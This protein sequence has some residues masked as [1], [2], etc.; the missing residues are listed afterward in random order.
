[1]GDLSRAG[2]RQRFHEPE[3]P[4][5]SIERFA[6][7]DEEDE[8]PG[9][10]AEDEHI[11]DAEQPLQEEVNVPQGADIN[12]ATAA[13]V[14]VTT[15]VAQAA[16]A[17]KRGRGRPPK[18]KLTE[19][20]PKQPTPTVDAQT[21][22][23]QGELVAE[24]PKKT[25]VRSRKSMDAASTSSSA[26]RPSEE[27]SRTPSRTSPILP[28]T[29]LA[30]KKGAAT[31]SG[32]PTVDTL[33]GLS[34][35]KSSEMLP[36]P[37]A[38][39]RQP[40]RPISPA[41][42]AGTAQKSNPAS[43]PAAAGSQAG[44]SA[45]K[46]RRRVSFAEPE[47]SPPAST[48]NISNPLKPASQASKH[49]NG[50][51]PYAVV[52]GSGQGSNAETVENAAENDTAAAQPDQEDQPLSQSL[53]KLSD[54][55]EIAARRGKRN[56]ST[57]SVYQK[58][59]IAEEKAAEE[60]R[61]AREQAAEEERLAKER[62]AEEK[63]RL[64]EKAA[65]ERK[66]A[67]AE[68]KAAKDAAK[69]A[70]SKAKAEAK[71][72]KEAE[73]DSKRKEKEQRKLTNSQK[74]SSAEAKVPQPSSPAPSASNKTSVPII[75]NKSD[76]VMSA[77]EHDAPAASP[78]PEPAPAPESVALPSSSPTMAAKTPKQTTPGPN[79][80]RSTSEASSPGSASTSRSQRD[81]RS[82][83]HF[84]TANS[85]ATSKDSFPGSGQK[86]GNEEDSES[87]DSSSDEDDD[88]LNT[89]SAIKPKT[90]AQIAKEKDVTSTQSMRSTSYIPPPTQPKFSEISAANKEKRRQSS[91]PIQPPQPKFGNHSSFGIAGS[92]ASDSP[93][94]S[95]SQRPSAMAHMPS[96]KNQAAQALA[97]R[98]A[99][100]ERI[101][102]EGQAKAKKLH[103]EQVAL[104]KEEMVEVSEAETDSS[105][106]DSDS[107]SDES[108]DSDAKKATPKNKRLM[109]LRG[110]IAAPASAS[111]AEGK[112][113]KID[114]G[115]IK[116]R[117]SLGSSLK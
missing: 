117:F 1:M 59:K 73:K 40:A 88:D 7:I 114:F 92:R 81:S 89:T 116:K 51:A 3:R 62:V 104:R 71:A 28:A 65:E 31:A 60:E 69:E 13:E 17:R 50:D 115:G 41:E 79:T 111:K 61:L 49:T 57:I 54:A 106:G 93:G 90:P 38:P 6:V 12:G 33:P 98:H 23:K 85:Q 105:S 72:A 84:V 48:K 46:K 102:L 96:L 103:D 10:G 100:M 43:S 55:S 18:D 32:A 67:A 25:R 19:L 75:D 16:A 109:G 47:P 4:I 11:P 107:D 56:A 22:P 87:E 108:S 14:V 45:S 74:A 36:P 68:K 97:N 35:A 34:A 5:P 86:Q 2:K 80:D 76:I 110:D 26:A 30:A 29:S 15:P 101:R 21:G 64:K 99:E 58:E 42:A 112:K 83:V 95:Q 9:S 78:S 44:A 27:A 37:M 70:K 24:A 82:P 20:L 8:G 77:M 39:Q 94:P 63:R 66:K 52:N 91:T 53:E 113:K